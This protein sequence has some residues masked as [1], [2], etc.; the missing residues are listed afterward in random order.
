MIV[1]HFQKEN[2]YKQLLVWRGANYYQIS[3]GF[4]AKASGRFCKVWKVKGTITCMN[5]TPHPTSFQTICA[6]LSCNDHILNKMYKWI[7]LC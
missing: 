2:S 6:M 1:K 5:N 3:I 4:G 7:L